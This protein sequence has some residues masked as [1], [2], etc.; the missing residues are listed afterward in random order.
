MV[1]PLLGV[2]F[3]TRC[4]VL[5]RVVAV[6]LGASLVGC[7][8]LLS[9]FGHSGSGSASAAKAPPGKPPAEC[10]GTMAFS[11][12]HRASD[13]REKRV[14]D[15]ACG[16]QYYAEETQRES[17]YVQL[18]VAFDD[19]AP[20]PVDAALIVVGCGGMQPNERRSTGHNDTMCM[21]H[22]E[23]MS[24]GQVAWYAAMIE[25]KAVAAEL[26][27]LPIPEPIQAAF[28]A[29]LETATTLV[30]AEAAKL[31]PV[32]RALYLDV[33]AR[34]HQEREERRASALYRQYL[35]LIAKLDAPDKASADVLA[36]ARALR[37]TYVKECAKRPDFD[38]KTCLAGDVARPLSE[39]IVKVALAR[40][41]FALALA[42]NEL[43]KQEP[44]LSSA[45]SEIWV[46]QTAAMKRDTQ[47]SR[48]IRAS[49]GT[50][51]SPGRPRRSTCGTT[52]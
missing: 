40:R 2:A 3:M 22:V 35:D 25:P 8:G 26:A 30:L 31:D 34:I 5:A 11:Q 37:D 27:T 45:A 21:A 14:K 28:L 1:R 16:W 20:D 50:R 43:L 47:L 38:V 12:I 23:P 39:R 6:V 13:P 44:D 48:S 33:P 24:V 46:A 49:R 19:T 29:H 4:V 42:E 9:S 41:S 7:G 15:L 18:H 17:A 32:R 51:R 52:S 36:Q 10:A